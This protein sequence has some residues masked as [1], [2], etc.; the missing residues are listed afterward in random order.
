ML[1][2]FRYK[3]VE[4]GDHYINVYLMEEYNISSEEI[5][6]FA[7]FN[8]VLY[9]VVGLKMMSYMRLNH[10]L[11]NLELLIGKCLLDCLPF[12][13]FYLVWTYLFGRFFEILGV[14]SNID[15]N[16][17]DHIAKVSKYFF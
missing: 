16:L 9:L 12:G 10:T 14:D 13:I 2:H 6:M 1:S 5:G 15:G 3:K 7:I 4:D 17:F 11:G 8:L